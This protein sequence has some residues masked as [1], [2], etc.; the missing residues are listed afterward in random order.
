MAHCQ[1]TE[2]GLDEATA[3]VIVGSDLARHVYFDCRSSWVFP[4]AGTPGW[5]VLPLETGLPPDGVLLGNGPDTVFQNRHNT[6]GPAYRIG[7]WPGLSTLLHLYGQA[8]GIQVGDG[9]GFEPVQWQPGDLFLQY[10]DFGTAS[11]QFLETGL[12]NYVTMEQLPFEAAGGA[13]AVRV[14]GRV[15]E[16]PLEGSPTP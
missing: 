11:G 9:L 2:L 12:Y 5:Y 7:Y 15:S 4:A 1:G 8:T 16:R 6:Q 13:T 14:D 3:E 10:Y